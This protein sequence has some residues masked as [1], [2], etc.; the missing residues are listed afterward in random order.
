MATVN[1]LSTEPDKLKLDAG[2]TKDNRKQ[3]A[4]KLSEGLADSY[5]LYLKTQSVHWNVVGPMFYSLHK[6]T[7]EQYE[8]MATAIDEVAERIRAIGYTAPGSF[9]Q[10]EQLTS[11]KEE[12]DNLNAEEMCKQLMQDNEIIAKRLRSAV[13]E[14]EKVNDVKTADLLTERIGQHEENAWMLRALIS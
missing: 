14:A 3:L 8:D 4:N 7:E 6:L 10:F 13:L 5:L 2:I 12:P 9:K 11:I 1:I